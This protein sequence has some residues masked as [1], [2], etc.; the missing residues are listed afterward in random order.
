MLNEANENSISNQDSSCLRGV[1]TDRK[2]A[3]SHFVK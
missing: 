1:G 3:Q 2:A